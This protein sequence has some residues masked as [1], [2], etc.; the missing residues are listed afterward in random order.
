[1]RSRPSKPRVPGSNPGGHTKQ[2]VHVLGQAP[3]WA[4][5]RETDALSWRRETIRRA[6]AMAASYPKRSA[7]RWALRREAATLASL[8]LAELVRL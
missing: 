4:T 6:L 5:P 1:M 3:R 8:S 7:G 2:T